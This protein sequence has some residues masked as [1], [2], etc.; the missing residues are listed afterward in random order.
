MASL[1]DRTFLGQVN[2]V[3]CKW[4]AQK[5]YTDLHMLLS[6]MLVQHCLKMH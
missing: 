1:M 6:V 4:F 3:F 5:V 2:Y